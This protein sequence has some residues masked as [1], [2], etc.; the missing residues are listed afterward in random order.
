MGV[1]QVMDM[2]GVARDLRQI[3]QEYVTDVEK[4]DTLH[5]SV[6]GVIIVAITIAVTTT[7]DIT[8]VGTVIVVTNVGEKDIMHEIVI[9]V[10]IVVTT[11]EGTTIEETTIVEII[12]AGITI[13]RVIIEET[14]IAMI[15][16]TSVART[17]TIEMVTIVT[18][19]GTT[20]MVEVMVSIADVVVVVDEAPGEETGTIGSRLE[21]IYGLKIGGQSLTRQHRFAILL[22]C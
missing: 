13:A 22:D 10:T 7:A 6:I 8:I 21:R 20:T 5:E 16:A 19:I 3:G 9:E 12:T 17:T 1:N 18:M 14:G 2:R 11:T 4:K 15:A